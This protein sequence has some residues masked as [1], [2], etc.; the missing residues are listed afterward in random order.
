MYETASQTNMLNNAQNFGGGAQLQ[1]AENPP[2]TARIEALLDETMSNLLDTTS[3]LNQTHGRL[4]G[5]APE[6][7]GGLSKGSTDGAQPVEDRIIAR[8]QAVLSESRFAR[9]RACDLANRI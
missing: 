2:L 6:V 1:A 8:L 7:A 5:F 4:F 9:Q 3:S